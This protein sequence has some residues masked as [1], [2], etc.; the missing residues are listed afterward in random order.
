MLARRQVC[1]GADVKRLGR[2]FRTKD[3]RR[4]PVSELVKRRES[5]LPDP[6]AEVAGRLRELREEKISQAPQAV[7]VVDYFIIKK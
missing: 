3:L 6:F 5:L 7:A 1:L 4:V 2:T